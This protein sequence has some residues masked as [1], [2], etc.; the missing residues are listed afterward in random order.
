[1]AIF[2]MGGLTLQRHLRGG[3]VRCRTGFIPLGLPPRVTVEPYPGRGGKGIVEDGWARLVGAGGTELDRRRL[4]ELRPQTL[5]WDDLGLL[6]YT[7][8]ALWTWLVLPLALDDPGLCVRGRPGRRLEVEVP[9]GSPGGGVTHVLHLDAEGRTYRHEEGNLVHHLSGHCDFGGAVL[10][11]NRRTQG[12]A[13][14]LT[15]AW[16]HVVAAHLLPANPA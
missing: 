16:A 6:S 15:V 1:M 4:G 11:T 2:S 3:A 10:A 13:H 7:A 12:R 14:D 5:R 9:E 8:A